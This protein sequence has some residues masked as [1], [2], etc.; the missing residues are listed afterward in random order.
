MPLS[1]RE[2]RQWA[3]EITEL[4]KTARESAVNHSKSAEFYRGLV[5]VST[6]QGHGGE[7]AKA[8]MAATARDHDAA[9]E[10]L[11]KSATKM[12]HCAG[13]AHDIAEKIN[14]ILQDAD[15]YPAVE[16]NQDTNQV[17]PPD[18]SNMDKDTKAK[19]AAKVTDLQE[20]IAAIEATGEVVDGD[21]ARAIATA[22]GTSEPDLKDGTP[23][24]LPDGTVRKD[25]PARVRAAAAA[26]EGVYGRAPVTPNDWRMA[27]ALNPN[28]YAPKTHGAPPE[29]V[30]GRFTPQPGKGVVRSNMFIPAEKVVNTAKDLEDLQ[31][32]RFFPNNFGDHRG[33]DANAD[34][35]ASRVSVFVDYENGVVVTRQ[36]P[37][38]NVDGQRGGAMAAVPE[39]HVVQGQNGRLTLDYNTFDAYEN[40]VGKA[41]NLTVNGRVTLDP[42]TDGTVGMGG[43]TTI[44]PSMETYQYRDGHA[45]VQ[46]QWDPANSGSEYGPG[47]SLSRHHWVGDATIQ[48]V[49]PDMPGW[50]W[51]LENANPFG[52]DPFIDHTTRL[53]DPSKGAIPTIGTGR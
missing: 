46:L 1:I 52:G 42:H 43:S 37:T 49:R 3:P 18:T 28:S 2:L 22:T 34:V 45:P 20:R 39:V 33:P 25:D 21:L 6:W 48:P 17:T 8:G 14:G 41:M 47:T 36:N 26:F 19:V 53:T 16:V 50:K 51:E 29:I 40:P 12:E 44:Y 7:A 5:K 38:V 11:V 31:R 10:S 4:A 35:E 30:A 32:G 27:D 15:A 9:A 13:E 24:P 23:T